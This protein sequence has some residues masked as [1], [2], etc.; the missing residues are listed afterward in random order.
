MRNIFNSR[1]I[2]Q[3][4]QGSIINFCR[5]GAYE[6]KEVYGII[7]TPRCDLC[8]SKVTTIHYLP[9]ISLND[10]ICVD[11][12]NIF[13]QRAIA[14]IK[15][16]IKNLME[17][18]NLS[19]NLFEMFSIDILETKIEKLITKKNDFKEIFTLANKYNLLISEKNADFSHFKKQMIKEY[20]KISQ[21]IF[22]ELRE[23]RFKE[24]YLMESWEEESNYKIILSREIGAL[25]LEFAQKIAKG[26]HGSTIQQADLK[27]SSIDNINSESFIC[28]LATLK[29]PFIEHLIQHFF[30]NFGRIGIEDH[31]KTLESELFNLAIN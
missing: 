8:H 7:I 28:T 14:E 9:V 29:S 4:E 23:N 22:K 16:K 25:S 18:N 15:Q 24:F 1:I 3:I 13:S 2:G 19:Y 21:S 11:F 12:W 6:G 20:P 26:I 27:F 31:R 10:W 5:A 17:K 30:L